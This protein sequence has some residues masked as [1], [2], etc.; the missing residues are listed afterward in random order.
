MIAIVFYVKN[1]IFGF[2]FLGKTA[3]LID[4]G[5]PLGISTERRAE[6]FFIQN[7]EICSLLFFK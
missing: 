6:N 1:S 5:Q 3:Q 4:F 2:D 7:L